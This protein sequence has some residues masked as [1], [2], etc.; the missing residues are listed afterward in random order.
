MRGLRATIPEPSEPGA[1]RARARVPRPRRAARRLHGRARRLRDGHRAGLLGHRRPPAGA[2]RGPVEARRARPRRRPGGQG[3]RV[4]GARQ[5]RARRRRPGAAG[6]GLRL[7]PR[8]RARPV[9][10]SR[11]TPRAARGR[12]CAALLPWPDRPNR[13]ALPGT[14][15]PQENPQCT[16]PG[17]RSPAPF[18][19]S[20]VPP[21]P[22]R[23]QEDATIIV[24]GATLSSEAEQ[25]ARATPAAP[26]W[27]ATR[28]TPTSRSSRCAT[29]SP[30]RPASTSSRASARKCASRSAVR[31]CRAASTCAG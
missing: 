7:P 17:W 1:A 11:G 16:R 28:T 6:A 10:H 30:S 8:A 12:R 2:D 4:R 13:T 27:S 22:R 18:S 23:L 31:A 20:P 29:R 14:S 24:T 26:T 19:L 15:G 25:Q 9:A 21:T 5:V 3:L